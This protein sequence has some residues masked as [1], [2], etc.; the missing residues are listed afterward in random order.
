MKE[1]KKIKIFPCPHVEMWI[2]VTD[3]M[4]KDLKECDEML[5]AAVNQE[6][7]NAPQKDCKTCSWRDICVESAAGEYMPC[8]SDQVKKKLLKEGTEED[9]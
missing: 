5:T 9:A 4:V 3:Q 1:V 8:M 6:N 7:W 2:S